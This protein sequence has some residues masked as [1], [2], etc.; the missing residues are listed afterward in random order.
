MATDEDMSPVQAKPDDDPAYTKDGSALGQS[1]DS[2]S[3]DEEAGMA[4]PWYRRGSWLRHWKHGV[5]AVIF[6]LFTG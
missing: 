5:Y 6:L 2:T 1:H 3:S 4:R